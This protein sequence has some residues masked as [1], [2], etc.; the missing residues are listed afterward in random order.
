MGSRFRIAKGFAAVLV[1]AAL[2]G[3]VA[4]GCDGDGGGEASAEEIQAVED[5]LKQAFES[6][7]EDADFFFAHVTDNL[8]E[9]VLFSTRA[10]CQA[11]AA[12]CIG[13]PSA[14]E[15]IAATE[16]DGDSASSTVTA[17]FG[18]F[19]V[20]LVR[21]GDVWM[22][23]SLEA[24]SD[25]VPAGAASV[26]LGLTEFA[27]TLDSAGIPA[28]G[29]FAFHVTNDGAQPHEVIVLS[30]PP[31]VP[32]QEAL[33][34]AGE[35]EPP[36]G[37]KVFIQPGQEVDMAFESMLAPGRYALVCFF[38]DRDDPEM[39]PHAEKGM[40]AEFTVGGNGTDATP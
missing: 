4:A 30:V 23:D 24:A 1:V 31:D 29:N 40:L 16:I 33:E 18:M 19:Q 3:A 10:D 35:E 34:S 38:P 14:I 7:G 36:V 39:T 22:V 28:D 8:I 12:D 32:L 20:G 25:T 37:F 5:I 11:N 27:F 13:E 9:T 21:E 15:S 2:A 6:G 26:E 17:D